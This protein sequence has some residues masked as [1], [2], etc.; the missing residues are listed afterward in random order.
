MFENRPGSTGV[1]GI[2]PH[3]SFSSRQ[4]YSFPLLKA[5]DIVLTLKEI[6]I[7]VVEENLAAPEKGGLNQVYIT[8]S[9][10]FRFCKTYLSSSIL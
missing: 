9:P 10:C 6:G 2:G 1:R 7:L 3:A 5:N 8:L 4:A